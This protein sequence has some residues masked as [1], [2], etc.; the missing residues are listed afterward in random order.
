MGRPRRTKAERATRL[1]RPMAKQTRELHRVSAESRSQ[2]QR[3]KGMC[4]AAAT[5]SGSSRC[6]TYFPADVR[7]LFFL[8]LLYLLRSSEV[9]CSISSLFSTSAFSLFFGR[10]LFSQL[11]FCST[12]PNCQNLTDCDSSAARADF[13]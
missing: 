1:A 11:R 2:S 4:S 7:L 10:F 3:S 5:A 12:L 8:L 13:R 6:A 9:Q